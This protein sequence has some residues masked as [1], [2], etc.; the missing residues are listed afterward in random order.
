[1]IFWDVDTQVDFMDRKGRLYVPGAETI[2]PNLR[3]LTQWA[4]QHHILV[5]A[6]MCAHQKDDPEFQ[7]YPPHCLVGTPGQQKIPETQLPNRFLVPNCPVDIPANLHDYDQVV[8]EKQQVDVFTNPNMEALL[9]ALGSKEE[10][11]LYGVVTEICV[12]YAARGLLDRGYRL[13]LVSD[14]VRHLDDA[15]AR[16]TLTEIGKRAGRIASAREAMREQTA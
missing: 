4:K 13:T 2:I 1:M 8:V 5:V 14:A 15:R 9:A 3:S 10:I 11:V 6:S 7:Q 16:A 12:A